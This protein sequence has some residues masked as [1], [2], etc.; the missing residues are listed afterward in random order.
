MSS[1]RMEM[2]RETA[3]LTHCLDDVRQDDAVD[4]IFRKVLDASLRL[5]FLEV[6][7]RPVRVDLPGESKVT[8]LNKE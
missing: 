5:D 1:E 8:G 6:V 2:R 4:D 7:V 3:A